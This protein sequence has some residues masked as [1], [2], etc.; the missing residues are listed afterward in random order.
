MGYS[1]HAS[2]I[3]AFRVDDFSQAQRTRGIT[4]GCRWPVSGP[5]KRGTFFREIELLQS[6]RQDGLRERLTGRALDD[7]ASAQRTPVFSPWLRTASRSAP[8]AP[9]FQAASALAPILVMCSAPRIFSNSIDLNC[10]D[11]SWLRS[12]FRS[13]HLRISGARWRTPLRRPPS[14]ILIIGERPSTSD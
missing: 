8:I 6:D 13:S 4:P 12:P 11:R 7:K 3:V 10:I 1:D 9:V 14:K 2:G 5:S